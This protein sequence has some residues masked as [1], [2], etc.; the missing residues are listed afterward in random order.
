[1]ISRSKRKFFTVK[2]NVTFYEQKDTNTFS[3][4]KYNLDYFLIKQLLHES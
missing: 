3:C 2:K 4:I 1:M